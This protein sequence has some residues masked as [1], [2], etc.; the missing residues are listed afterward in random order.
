MKFSLI[1]IRTILAA[2][3]SYNLFFK[4]IAGSIRSWFAEQYIQPKDGDR[5][6]FKNGMVYTLK[7]L[8]PN[9]EN[10]AHNMRTI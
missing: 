6:F 7:K 9:T 8:R 1:D 5:I 2:S 10:M 3:S 4:L